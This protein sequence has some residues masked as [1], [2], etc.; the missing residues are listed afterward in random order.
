MTNDNL[1]SYILSAV[2]TPTNDGSVAVLFKSQTPSDVTEEFERYLTKIGKREHWK[3][4]G[5]YLF[6]GS[7]N[8]D[9]LFSRATNKQEP[10]PDKEDSVLN[11]PWNKWDTFI[12][13]E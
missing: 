11:W 6:F 2:N 12:I 1:F 5:T 3:R 7:N 10:Y 8:E 13:T 9:I 4:G